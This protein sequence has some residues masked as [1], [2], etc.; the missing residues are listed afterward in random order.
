MKDVTRIPPPSDD[1]RWQQVQ[2]TMRR[3]G[4]QPDALIT[5]LQSIQQ[6]FGYLSEEA[7]HFVAQVLDVPLSEVYGVATFFHS[8]TF[9]PQ[10]RHLCTVCM[11][12]ACYTRGAARIYAALERT[13]GTYQD[14]AGTQETPTLRSTPCLGMCARAPVVVFDGTLPAGLTMVDVLTRIEEARGNDPGNAG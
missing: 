10:P 2:A 14:R 7:M 9:Q 5:T 4:Y 13:I 1:Q 8:F 3:H 11:G 6:T 12:I